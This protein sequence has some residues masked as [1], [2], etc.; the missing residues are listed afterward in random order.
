MQW[1]LGERYQYHYNAAE[2]LLSNK[3]VYQPGHPSSI[4]TCQG[5]ATRSRTCHVITSCTGREWQF[6]FL[7]WK[8]EK[9]AVLAGECIRWVSGSSTTTITTITHLA[10]HENVLT[11]CHQNKHKRPFT[12]YIPV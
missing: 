2:V 4:T 9:C 1:G 6:G 8:E 10:R 12:T 5:K 7:V 11:R 3:G